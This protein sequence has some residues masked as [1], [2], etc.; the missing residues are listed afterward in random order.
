MKY[1]SKFFAFF[2]LMAVVLTLASCGKISDP[3]PYEGSGYPHVYP[4]Y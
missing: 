2:V 3:V 4:Q 1:I